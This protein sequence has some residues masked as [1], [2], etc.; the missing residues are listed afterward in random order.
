MLCFTGA[1]PINQKL[2]LKLYSKVI[3][4]YNQQ[5]NC[6][7]TKC[8]HKLT[9]LK[10]QNDQL[11]LYFYLQ[12]FVIELSARAIDVISDTYMKEPVPY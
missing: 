10:K 2:F 3:G 5:K 4:A 12:V 1:I 9:Y 7:K 11:T 6:Q 8:Y